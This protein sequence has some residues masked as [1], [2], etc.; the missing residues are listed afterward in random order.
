MQVTFIFNNV[1]RYELPLDALNLSQVFVD[2]LDG[3]VPT[4]PVCLDLSPTQKPEFVLKVLEFCKLFHEHPFVLPKPP[5]NNRSFDKLIDCANP[6]VYM[7]LFELDIHG[8]NEYLKTAN[9]LA[10]QPL[11]TVLSA[12]MATAIK[13]IS[14]SEMIE[15]L[16]PRY[17]IKYNM[18]QVLEM[19]PYLLNE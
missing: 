14:R 17:P 2:M 15:L 1:H 9:W 7:H 3:E 16:G 11:I 18:K 6:E 8:L 12:K 10:V 19:H 13:Y 5:L 4:N